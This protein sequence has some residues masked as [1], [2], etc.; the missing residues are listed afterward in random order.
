MD[1]LF[2]SQ[3]HCQTTSTR[4]KQLPF[5]IAIALTFMF[6]AFKSSDTKPVRYAPHS[7]VACL[8]RASIAGD[9]ASQELHL[10]EMVQCVV[11]FFYSPL[12]CSKYCRRINSLVSSFLP[13]LK[14]RQG[15]FIQAKK[16]LLQLD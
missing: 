14:R 12:D 1:E 3:R 8:P 10:I 15:G 2:G 11:D 9:E 4:S 16:K 5:G 6:N 13:A 7:A